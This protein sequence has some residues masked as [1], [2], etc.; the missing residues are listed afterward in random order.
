M[1]VFQLK[2]LDVNTDSA[3][4]TVSCTRVYG[5]VKRP[6]PTIHSRHVYKAG[7]TSTKQVVNCR[8]WPFHATVRVTVLGW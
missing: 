7:V 2:V 1:S 5:G 8:V 3:Y 4:S 6:H